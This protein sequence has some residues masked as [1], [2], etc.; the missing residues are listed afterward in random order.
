MPGRRVGR[1]AG[2]VAIVVALVG[3]ATGAGAAPT[4]YPVP[5]TFGMRGIECTSATDCLAY[6]YAGG[7]TMFLLPFHD[8]EVSGQL[9]V[10]G[11]AQINGLVCPVE[12]T[13][14]AVGQ[15][16]SGDGVVVPIVFG[17]IG[18]AVAVPGTANLA[19]ID[20]Y[21]G[22]T[23]CTAVGSAVVSTT[24]PPF[25]NGA[26]AQIDDGA[27]NGVAQLSSAFLSLSGVACPAAGSCV[28]V[29]S[30][31]A[32]PSNVVAGVLPVSAGVPGTAQ[33]VA[34][35]PPFTTVACENATSCWTAGGNAVVPIAGGVAG[36]P[37][38]I[39]GLDSFA[40]S[41]CATATQCYLTGTSSSQ[42]GFLVP[43]ANDVVGAVQTINSTHT[44]NGLAC[45]G[46]S[47]C[48]A[49][50]TVGN[51]GSFTGAIVA[52]AIAKPPPT[53]GSVA[54]AGSGTSLT[55]TVNGSGFDAWAPEPSPLVPV[56]CVP[57]DTSYD[58]AA[59]TLSFTDTTEGWSAGTPGS[60]IGLTLTSWSDSQVV[61]GFGAGYVFPKLAHGDAFQIS[62]L[63]TVVSGT[64]TSATTTPAPTIKSVAF[65]GS[66]AA[67]TITVKGR[68]FG[69]RVPLGD[70]L[71]PLT[72]VPGDT[73]HD[74]ASDALFFTDATGGWT[75]GKPL[76]CI[77]LTV[78]SWKNAQ[79][80]LGLGAEYPSF[81]PVTTGD[82]FQ[83][84]LLG[85]AFS[86]TVG[87]GPAPTV[88]SVV[89]TGAGAGLTITVTGR[90]FG[91]TAPTP[92]PP[93][94]LNCVPGDTSFDYPAGVLSFQ[95]A[96]KGWTAG[97]TGDCVGLIVRKWSNTKVV[98]RLGAD[99]AN[100]AAV[101]SG[102]AYVLQIDGT[103]APGTV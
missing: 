15:G 102:D 47:D 28:A 95:D 41:T 40:G 62:V 54:F 81:S 67:L 26:V 35:L 56:S 42:T 2:A 70:P 27:P 29:G 96:S 65:G 90:G 14:Y 82:S 21:P 49:A 80:V 84:G 61:F 78:Q 18:A 75:A 55:V 97:Q 19:G 59:G 5:G 92:D 7:A 43:I 25:T 93:S 38:P 33:V 88:S 3:A 66:G 73:S 17:I 87:G 100:F 58:Y 44:V 9:T 89:F 71:G 30:A 94:P 36:T 23:T 31:L 72:C 22:T 8:G 101:T 34:G 37:D 98:L 51:N 99:Y 39:S 83:I 52:N 77:G 63:T 45:V 76:D 10:P 69:T 103:S 79:I 64:A 50:A 20:C 16:D 6:G 53:I 11:M 91:A 24:T 74:F 4:T 68:N 32:P 86:S 46:P 85:A 12:A 1:L 57:G 60:C 48:V 13:C